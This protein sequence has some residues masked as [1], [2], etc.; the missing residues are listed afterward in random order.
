MSFHQYFTTF[1]RI[2]KIN[3]LIMLKI[4]TLLLS[5]FS[6]FIPMISFA[7]EAAEEMS[8]DQ[9]IDAFFRPV[10]DAVGTV[11]FLFS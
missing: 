3:L 6:V 2:L 1:G 9:R 10:A 4:K 11:I 8:I 5:I 7:Q